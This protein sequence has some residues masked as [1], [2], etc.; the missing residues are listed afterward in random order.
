[1]PDLTIYEY[2][3]F[4]SHNHADQEWTTRLAERLEQEDWQGR[5][6]KV[7]FSPWDIRP[8]QSIPKE[9]ENALPKSRKVG[10]IL[11]PDAV[12]SA[13]V[14]LERLVTTYIAVSARDERLIPLYRRDCDIPALLQPIL[15]LDF[16]D[17][18]DFEAAYQTLLS[19]IK[20]EPLPR[21][22]L[23][24]AKKAVVLPPVIPPP[25]IDSF[26][27]PDHGEGLRVREKLPK[28]VEIFYAYSHKDAVL[29]DELAKHLSLLKRQGIIHEW[30]DRRIGAG[31]DWEG[32]ISEHLNSAHIILLLISSDFLAS[33]YCYDVEV[34][35]AMERH[36]AGEARVVPIILRTCDW[37]DAPFGKLQALPKDAKPVRRWED[38]DEAFFDIVQGL[39]QAAEEISE[40][41]VVELPPPSQPTNI[42]ISSGATIM[43]DSDYL[44]TKLMQLQRF[45]QEDLIDESV[46]NEYQRRLLDRWI[47][48]E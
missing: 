28:S 30:H 15:Y 22:S 7:F 18:A 11:S 25:P 14:D 40:S 8:G 43:P 35:T 33:D 17:D 12:D 38:Q 44:L 41:M 1:M 10:L 24:S 4:L 27:A 13:W 39:R 26:V 48:K 19:V 37:L 47:E 5:R 16:R 2:D 20:D 31:T 9:I 6:L 36:D 3:I 21:R 46:K 29:R 32:Q 42:P 23:R 45:E 34:K